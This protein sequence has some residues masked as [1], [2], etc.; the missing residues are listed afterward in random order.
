[1]NPY[2]GLKF[3]ILASGLYFGK[4]FNYIESLSGIEI[5]FSSYLNI[6]ACTFNYIESLS[7][8][9]ILRNDRNQGKRIFLFQLH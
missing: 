2:Q 6:V 5:S 7:G 1:L 9:E 3:F 4:C 8:I